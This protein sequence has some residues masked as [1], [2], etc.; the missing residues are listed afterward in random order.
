MSKAKTKSTK[1]KAA[2]AVKVAKAGLTVLESGLAT[3]FGAKAKVKPAKVKAP[4]A[5]APAKVAREQRNGI[6][7][8][9]A[10]TICGIVWSSLDQMKAAG[11]E[12]TLEALRQLV[13]DARGKRPAADAT[14]RTQRQRWIA[15]HA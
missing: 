10:E 7:R 12:Y 2:K 3:A 5:E 6:T 11:T 9:G 8:P 13:D 1:P 4:K 14:L 15:F